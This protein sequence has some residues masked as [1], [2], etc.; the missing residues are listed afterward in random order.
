MSKMCQ[1]KIN[2]EDYGACKRCGAMFFRTSNGLWQSYDD[3]RRFW[4]DTQSSP[5]SRPQGAI[6]KDGK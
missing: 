4:P 2:G 3:G 5:L 6:T 1:H